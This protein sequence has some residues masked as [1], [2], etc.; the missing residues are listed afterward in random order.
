MKNCTGTVIQGG[1]KFQVCRSSV[2]K[3]WGSS[4]GDQAGRTSVNN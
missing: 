1:E 4:L 2:G 3:V